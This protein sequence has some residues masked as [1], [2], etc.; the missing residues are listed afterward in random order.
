TVLFSSVED[1]PDE[2]ARDKATA[3]RIGPKSNVTF[4]LSAGGSQV[5]GALAFGKMTEERAWPE[6]LVRRLR[7]AAQ[8]IASALERKRAELKLRRALAEIEQLRARL[9]QENV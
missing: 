3:R 7:L 8:V 1:L 2:A 6:D 4:P 5:F 9:R